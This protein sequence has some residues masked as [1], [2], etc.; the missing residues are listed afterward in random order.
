MTTC[1]LILFGL[2]HPTPAQR[3]LNAGSIS[4]AMLD[5]YYTQRLF[6]PAPGWHPVEYNPL[7]RSFMTHGKALAYGETVGE[8]MFN[9]WLGDRMK[10]SHNRVIRKLWW[11]PQVTMIAGHTWGAAFTAGARR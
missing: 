3:L 10:R 9:A 11:V 7:S 5:T 4:A 8:A 6:A 2:C 1:L